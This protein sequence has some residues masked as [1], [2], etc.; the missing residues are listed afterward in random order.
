MYI[1]NLS[2]IAF[3]K[4]KKKIYFNNSDVIMVRSLM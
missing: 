3:H 1:G 2:T 4:A